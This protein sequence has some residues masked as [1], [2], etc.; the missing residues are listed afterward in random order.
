MVA[1]LLKSAAKIPRATCQLFGAIK[2]ISNIRDSVILVHGPKGCVYHINYILGMR[3]D[4]TSNVYSTCMDE[5][6]VIFGAGD[7]LK[8]AIIELDI[9]FGPALIAV[10]SVSYTHLRA[11]ETD[12][13]L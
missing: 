1:G 11:H 7:K 12:S 4:K 9:E 10:L 6:D 13:Y 3:G 5:K 2:A 8:S